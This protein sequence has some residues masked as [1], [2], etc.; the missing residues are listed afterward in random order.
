[1]NDWTAMRMKILGNRGGNFHISQRF[2][3][4]ELNIKSK[5]IGDYSKGQKIIISPIKTYAQTRTRTGDIQIFSLT[6]SQ[7]SYLG[8]GSTRFERMI[9]AMSRR[10]HNQLDHEPAI[11]FQSGFSEI[12][13]SVQ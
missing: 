4:N 13:P 1:M 12:N 6:L 9:S 8:V 3:A 11:D 5:R 7:L 10:R 2:M